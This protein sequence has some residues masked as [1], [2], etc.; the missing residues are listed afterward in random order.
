MKTL[1]HAFAGETRI[2]LMENDLPQ[3]IIIRRDLCLNFGDTVT[4]KVTA[5]HPV[6]RGYFAMAGRGAVFIPTAEKLTE[7][8]T[9]RL[10]IVKEARRDKDAVG[11]ITDEE[12]TPIVFEGETVSAAVMDEII[13][14]AMLPDV[15]LNGGSILHIER[16]NVCWTI[17]VDSGKS[18]EALSAVNRTAAAEAARQ[19]RLKNM[20]G[21]ILVDFTGTKRIGVRKQLEQQ[22]R[23]ALS[24]DSLAHLKGWTPGGL[25]EIERRRER[26]DL[27]LAYSSSN[28]FS[29]YYR[30]RRALDACRLARPV[31]YAAPTVLPLLHQAGI[32]AKV[33]L[34]QPSDYLDISED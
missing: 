4:A 31:V 28:P 24:A 6:L 19:I 2:A 8:Q 9:V 18:T 21:I 22:M 7:G 12:I 29:T 15:P 10:K 23:D 25:L 30:V 20:G 11:H 16:T 27:W 14:E 5:Y 13:D 1:I 34:G 26:A 17:D 32:R 3:E 33:A